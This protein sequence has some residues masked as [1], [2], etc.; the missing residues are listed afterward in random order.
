MLALG[1]DFPLP[2]LFG[3]HFER[4]PFF[5]FFLTEKFALRGRD[6]GGAKPGNGKVFPPSASLCS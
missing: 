1:R 6:G 4:F 5:G 3:G 2:E